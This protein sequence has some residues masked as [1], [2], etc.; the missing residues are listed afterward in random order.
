MKKFVRKNRPK[1]EETLISS[2]QKAAKNI[3]YQNCLGFYLKMFE[4]L[5]IFK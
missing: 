2:L 5:Q 3:S 1:N 4:I